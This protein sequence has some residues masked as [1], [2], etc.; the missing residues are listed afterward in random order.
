MFEN[1][2]GI[3]QKYFYTAKY[4]ISQQ[5]WYF[6][7]R[8][9]NMFWNALSKFSQN[10]IFEKQWNT[11]IF[12]VNYIPMYIG[13]VSINPFYIIL[14]LYILSRH[15]CEFM[16]V[17]VYTLCQK[18]STISFYRYINRSLCLHQV[19]WPIRRLIIMIIYMLL[20]T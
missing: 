5:I 18:H 3:S 6:K 13:S 4:K 14:G 8:S 15:F 17:S 1:H 11:K 12:S 20:Y 7:I 2:I 19:T 10:N 16:C 9:G